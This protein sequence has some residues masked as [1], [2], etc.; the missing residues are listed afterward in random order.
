MTAFKDKLC[1]DEFQSLLTTA[2]LGRKCAVFGEI[3][4]TN[5]YLKRTAAVLDDGFAVLADI[6]TGGR[7]RL[8]KSFESPS[9]GLYRLLKSTADCH[10]K[11]FR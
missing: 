10:V 11:R 2:K 9:G 8:G 4:S 1:S 3:G 5:T 7:G 6:Q